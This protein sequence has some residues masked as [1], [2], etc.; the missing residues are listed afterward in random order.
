MTNKFYVYQYIHPVTLLPFYIGKGTNNRMMHHLRETFDNTENK[1]KYAVIQGLKNKGLLPIVEKIQENID[2]SAAYELEETLIKK[3]GRRDLD[4]NGILT[5]ICQNNRPPSAKGKQRI[6]S[7]EVKDKHARLNQER[8]LGKSYE[9]IYGI[10]RAKE[11]KEKLPNVVGENNP[12]YGKT[13][14]ANTKS[15]MSEKAK[16]RKVPSRLGIPFTEEAKILIGLNNPNRRAIHTPYGKFTSAEEFVNKIGL[17][18]SNGLRRILKNCED[19]I[20]KRHVVNNK[21]LTEQD[22]GKSFK[23]IGYY[24][25]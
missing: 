3:Y 11:I 10:T 6:V 7:Q 13:H 1:K 22:I 17:I 12:F 21:L 20:T 15:I 25:L 19:I 14:S 2:E 18:S 9:E 16:S 8:C 4:E 24:F 5:N 23:D